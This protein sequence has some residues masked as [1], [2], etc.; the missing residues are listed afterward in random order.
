MALSEREAWRQVKKLA[1]YAALTDS[2]SQRNT[3]LHDIGIEAERMLAQLRTGVHENPPLLV[4]LNPGR[5]R[6][7]PLPGTAV[8]AQEQISDRV[9]EIAYRHADDGNDYKHDFKAGVELWTVTMGKARCVVLAGKDGQ[10]LW[11]DF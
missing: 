6:H 7:N 9:Y 10:D 2:A 1:L 4:G 8:R 5:V 11:Q 3:A